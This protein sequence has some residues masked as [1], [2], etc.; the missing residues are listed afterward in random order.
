M[1]ADAPSFPTTYTGVHLNPVTP[2]SAAE[3]VAD[4]EEQNAVEENN[5]NFKVVGVVEP[6]VETVICD[7]TPEQLKAGVW[8]NGKPLSTE[9]IFGIIADREG[10]AKT[11]RE[12]SIIKGKIPDIM[13]K[14]GFKQLR[15]SNKDKETYR[16]SSNPR[17]WRQK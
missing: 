9:T 15:M 2:R 11:G 6:S 3:G 14:L 5:N 7:R 17:V 12:A 8:G 16:I 1:R 10:V 13:A 4:S